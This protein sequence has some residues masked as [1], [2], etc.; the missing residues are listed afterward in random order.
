MVNAKAERV[1]DRALPWSRLAIEE[2]D[3]GAY[4]RWSNLDGQARE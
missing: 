3:V 2:G 4:P 1:G